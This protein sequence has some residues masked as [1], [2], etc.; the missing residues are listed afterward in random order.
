MCYKQSVT[1]VAKKRSSEQA[2]E[3]RGEL[4]KSDLI[5][6]RKIKMNDKH[7][8]HMFQSSKGQQNQT[9]KQ[10]TKQYLNRLIEMNGGT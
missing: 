4:Q 2:R 1:A 5:L 8:L 9:D 7:T 6:S 3:I 10:L